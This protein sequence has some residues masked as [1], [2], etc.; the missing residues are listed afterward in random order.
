MKLKIRPIQILEYMAVGLMILLSGCVFFTQVFRLETTVLFCGVTLVLLW[1]KHQSF[2]KKNATNIFFVGIFLM[3]NLFGNIGSLSTANYKDYLLLFIEIVCLICVIG[4]ISPEE[5]Q[6]KYTEIM[7]V[8]AVISLFCFFIQITNTSLVSRLANTSILSGYTIS[9]FHTWGW[10]YIFRRNAGPFWEPG[11]FQGY[12]TLAI[13]FIFNKRR[14]KGN[15]PILIILALTVLTTMST[16]GYI[17]LGVMFAYFVVLYAKESSKKSKDL[18]FTVIKITAL[19]F[20]VIFAVQYILTSS[21]VTNKF[22]S[23]NESYTR[24]LLDIVSSWD[25]VMQ[26]PIFGYGIMGTKLTSIW[27]TLGMSGNSSGLL[28]ALQF[29]GLFFGTLLMAAIFLGA[30]RTYNRLNKLVILLI[31]GLLFMTES[32]IT[33]PVYLGIIF[34]TNKQVKSR[35]EY[36]I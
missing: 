24:R 18:L 19:L 22:M 1:R 34:M 26:K 25:I 30:I 33:Y 29:F 13:L 27:M 3:I 28:A 11:A 9:W 20:A 5:F 2:S 35:E 21:T 31:F 7:A 8:I 6:G 17:L 14:L 15:Y 23:S 4:V 32:L 36:S 16:T 10:T 12:L